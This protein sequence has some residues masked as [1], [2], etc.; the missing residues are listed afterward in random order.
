MEQI[1]AEHNARSLNTQYLVNDKIIKQW[2]GLTLEQIAEQPFTFYEKGQKFVIR[3]VFGDADSDQTDHFTLESNGA[4]TSALRYLAPN[5]KLV[6]SELEVLDAKIQLNDKYVSDEAV[7][8]RAG[9]FSH[10]IVEAIQDQQVKQVKMKTIRHSSVVTT[11][12]LSIISKL[13][14]PD[15]GF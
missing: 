13:N 8:W 5:F 1:V 4:C 11:E 3:W 9:T 6:D 10:M 7:E 2:D 15:T 12:S 14:K